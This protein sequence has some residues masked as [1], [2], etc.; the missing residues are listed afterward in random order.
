MMIGNMIPNQLSS[1]YGDLTVLVNK[2]YLFQQGSSFWKERA[3][4]K[5][6]IK[7]GNKLF[8]LLSRCFIFSTPPPFPALSTSEEGNIIYQT[9]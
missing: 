4:F 1:Q 9:S 8:Y 7:I 2:E 3:T 5:F 6:S